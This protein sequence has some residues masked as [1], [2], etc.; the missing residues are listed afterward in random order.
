MAEIERS[1]AKIFSLFSHYR[2]GQF[3]LVC[4]GDSP[5]FWKLKR[6]IERLQQLCQNNRIYFHLRSRNNS[7]LS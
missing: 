2:P 7:R 4:N 5:R 3:L 1:E 6:R